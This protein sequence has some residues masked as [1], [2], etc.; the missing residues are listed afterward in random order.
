MHKALVEGIKKAVDIIVK[1]DTT[2]VIAKEIA[3]IG[4]KKTIEEDLKEDPDYQ[5]FKAITDTIGT[6]KSLVSCI[7]DLPDN[8]EKKSD[9]ADGD[10]GSENKEDSEKEE[11]KKDSSEN[12][13]SK[14]EKEGDNA[15]KN[16]KR[17]E[18]AEKSDA[19]S[20][21]S[22]KSEEEKIELQN[23]EIKAVE[24]GDK[25]IESAQ[26]KGNYG[27]M[28]VDQD[29]R[30]KGY[31]RISKDMVTKVDDPGHQGID[32]VYY[33]PNGKP[34][35]IIVDAKY[36]TAQLTDTLDGK[37]MSDNWIDKRLDESVG[38]EKADDIRM[39]V[40]LEPDNVAKYIGH[41]DSNGNVTYDKL[42]SEANIV[43][44]DV[45]VNA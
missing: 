25:K 35:Y 45:K 21:D 43:E 31:E 8:K 40:L 12:S 19:E 29:L 20:E 37:Q 22:E 1:S 30:S 38:K 41:V 33:N 17:E 39:E 10:T 11:N 14:E 42:D 13:N 32:G 27:E 16:V 15:E 6:L 18:D 34:K 24:S 7:K 3:K 4:V 9:E 2:K 5:D 44:K 28:K 26:E 36:G 23:N